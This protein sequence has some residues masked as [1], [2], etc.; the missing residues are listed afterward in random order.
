MK[1]LTRGITTLIVAASAVLALAG[2]VASPPS[3]GVIL[4]KTYSAAH[5]ENYTVDVDTYDYDCHY[6][7]VYDY[8]TGEYE[9]EY[10]CEYYMG[11]HGETEDRV[12]HIPDVW[13][14]LFEGE[15]SDDE[16][17]TRTV[18]VSENQYNEANKGYSIRIEEGKIFIAAR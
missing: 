4:D 15:N 11:D 10:I 17:V 8:S 3:E 1:S 5:D 12:R 18:E 7:D 13:T 14:V 2:C 16:L 9:Y 6:T